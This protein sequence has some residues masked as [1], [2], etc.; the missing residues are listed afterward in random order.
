MTMIRASFLLT[1][2]SLTAMLSCNSPET[3]QA[4]HVALMDTLMADYHEDHVRANP[5]EAIRTG[6][7]RSN[8]TLH[9]DISAAF[10][11]QLRAFYQNYKDLHGAIDR[12]ALDEKDRLSYDIIAFNCDLGLERQKFKEHLMPINQLWSQ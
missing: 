10:R 6:A 5:I 11:E 7:T 4:D 1:L 8:D 9:N 2:L 12:N 3:R